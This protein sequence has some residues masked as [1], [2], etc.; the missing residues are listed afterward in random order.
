MKPHT[1]R[2]LVWLAQVLALA[3]VGM[4]AGSVL[5][6]TGR[7]GQEPAPVAGLVVVVGG[8]WLLFWNVNRLVEET[9]SGD[10]D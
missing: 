6:Q 3:V 7:R 4:M 9:V 5:A 8:A 10:G 2:A 1:E